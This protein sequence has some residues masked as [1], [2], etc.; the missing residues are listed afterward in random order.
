M[1]SKIKHPGLTKVSDDRSDVPGFYF[2]SHPTSM[3]TFY[4]NFQRGSLQHYLHGEKLPR[5]YRYNNL[6]MI[7]VR[8]QQ[9]YKYYAAIKRGT[10]EEFLITKKCSWNKRSY[11][12]R[13]QT[14]YEGTTFGN[15][16]PTF[17]EE[18]KTREMQQMLAVGFLKL[19]G[20]MYAWFLFTLL[21]IF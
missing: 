12:S 15:Y 10:F 9:Y 17:V 6:R 16:V 14:L 7:K 18:N 4:E 1:R 21:N 5:G 2:A 19:E 20:F 13:L 3:N 8:E 11:K